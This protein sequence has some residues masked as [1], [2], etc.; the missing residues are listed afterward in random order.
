MHIFLLSNLRY[1]DNAYHYVTT[2]DNVHNIIYHTTIQQLCLLVCLPNYSN[3]ELRRRKLVKTYKKT[4]K[5]AILYFED[6]RFDVQ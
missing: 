3:T 4:D 6:C 2:F 5:R 1:V